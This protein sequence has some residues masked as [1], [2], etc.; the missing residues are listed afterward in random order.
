MICTEPT[1]E[2]LV[3][4]VNATD[5]RAAAAARERHTRL[6][7]PP[8]SLGELEELGARLSAISG[9]CPPPVPEAPVVV[10]AAA[11]HGVH[12]RGVSAWPQRV[13]GLMVA[14][15]AAGGAA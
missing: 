1:V 14:T 6:A 3:G 4:A 9:R 2:E 10:L 8:G 12:A 13:T 11:D 15:V 5:E 7:K